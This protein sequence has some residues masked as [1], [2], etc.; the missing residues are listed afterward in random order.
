MP[1]PLICAVQKQRKIYIHYDMLQGHELL[2]LVQP[3]I[4]KTYEQLSQ[5]YNL[6]EA[7]VP[8]TEQETDPRQQRPISLKLRHPPCKILFSFS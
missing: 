5:I 1:D 8:F 6:S 2:I 4:T 3:Y 7:E